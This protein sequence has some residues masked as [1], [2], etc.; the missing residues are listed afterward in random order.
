MALKSEKG[1]LQAEGVAKI[2]ELRTTKHPYTG[3]P[4][5]YQQIAH[6]MGVCVST[7]YNAVK[8]KTHAGRR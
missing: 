2:F 1:R 4:W 6:E 3:R 5:T 7:V 8:G